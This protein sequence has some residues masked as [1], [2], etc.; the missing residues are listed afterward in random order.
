M[1]CAVMLLYKG[2]HPIVLCTKMNAKEPPHAYFFLLLQQKWPLILKSV[3]SN[4]TLAV[5]SPKLNQAKIHFLSHHNV[6]N[7]TRFTK[8]QTSDLWNNC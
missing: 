8:V 2:F 3:N 4:F 5:H 1:Y 7:I 6:C